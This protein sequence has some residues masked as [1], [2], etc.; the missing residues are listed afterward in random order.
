MRHLSTITKDEA[1]EIAK[2]INPDVTW[3]CTLS[4]DEYSITLT[5]VER[6][7]EIIII[8][9]NYSDSMNIIT[10]LVNG[11]SLLLNDARK[12]FRYAVSIDLQLTEHPYSKKLIEDMY[13]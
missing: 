9:W 12:I 7:N 3:I 11:N 10:Y 4:F 6:V 2:I 13:K 1:I 5:P 8:S